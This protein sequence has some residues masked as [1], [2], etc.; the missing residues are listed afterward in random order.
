M[1]EPQPSPY[2][3]HNEFDMLYSGSPPDFFA[4]YRQQLQGEHGLTDD[5]LRA[6]RPP[7]AT[8]G[9]RAAANK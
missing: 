3:W 9:R 4:G 1:L 8:R 7:A 5:D 6:W 2:Q